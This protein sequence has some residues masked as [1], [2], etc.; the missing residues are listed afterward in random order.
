MHLPLELHA[1]K[2]RLELTF[3]EPLDAGS[4]AV[5]NVQITT[6]SL[7]RSADYGSKHY[8][9]KLLKVQK[10][11]LSADGRTL[12]LDIPDLAP[13]WGL[14]LKYALRARSGQPVPGTIH[15]T[16]HRLGESAE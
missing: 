4:L 10:L 9:E 16:I 8:D 15:A 11:A 2:S 3:T 7:K 6:W 14:E 1:K 5:D 13:T 12:T